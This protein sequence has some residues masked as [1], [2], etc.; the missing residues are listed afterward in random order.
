MLKLSLSVLL[1]A[2]A[3]PAAAEDPA[4]P[5]LSDSRIERLEAGEVVTDVETENRNNRAEMICLIEAAPDEVWDVIMNYGDYED[6]FPD[7]L[8]AE[9]RSDGSSRLIYG[10]TRVPVFRNRTYELRDSAEQRTVDGETVFV[11][12]WEYVD[13]SGNM[14]SSTGFW[15]VEPYDA[16]RTLVRLVVHA[17]LGMSLP[18]AIVNWGTRRMLPGIAEG[19]QEQCDN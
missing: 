6:W 4:A 16:S 19:I 10:E 3:L 14:D 11:N 5:R 2:V 13:D 15:W 18:Q 9:V 8:E 7:Q 1:L 12:T 17:D